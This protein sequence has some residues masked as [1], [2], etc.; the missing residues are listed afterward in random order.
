MHKIHFTGLLLLILTLFFSCTN[1][2][3]PIGLGLMDQMGTDFTDTITVSAYSYLEDTINTTS[4]SA[5]MVGHIS[6]PVFGPS[7]ASIYTQMAMSANNVNFGENPVIDSCIF[8]LQLA[9]YYGDTTSRVG[10][11][12]HR[13]NE[14]PKNRFNY[15]QNNSLSYDPTPLNYQLTDYA[16]S[17]NQ[18]VV[19]DTAIYSPHVRIRLSQAFGQYLLNHQSEL[20]NNLSSILKGLYITAVSHTGN[21]GYMIL[22]SMTS[23]LSG[24]T[25]YYHND[26]G[27]GLRYKLVCANSSVRFNEYLHDYNQ[28][29]DPAF[30]QEVL[31][32][33]RSVGESVLY[34]QG[35]GGVK[36]RITFPYLKEAFQSLGNRVV[37]NKAELVVTDLSPDEPYL[38]H[39]TILTLQGIKE[40]TEAITYL[41]D[42]DY[43]TSTSY[44]GGTYNVENHEYRFRITEYVQK[45]ISGN[46]ELSNSVNLV[47][48]GSGVRANR[49]IF[50]GTNLDDSQ[51]LRLEISYTKY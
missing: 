15:Y 39:P 1:E 11:R 7:V 29:S 26:N 36:T 45:L 40:G 9:S 34:V 23:T 5:N 12:V 27:S 24:I 16:I 33:D 10:I 43:Y 19:V 37:I 38:T 35:T 47:V 41:P 14:A 50:G 42:D 21:T 17:P 44:F 28:S 49:L 51:R 31:H 20:N 8:T 46:G 6:D 48:R 25:I 3:S 30:I 13:L 32:G 4:L 22:T 2:N 18:E